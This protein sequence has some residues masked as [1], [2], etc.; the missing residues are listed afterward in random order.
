MRLAQPYQRKTH[1]TT[2]V[3]GLTR[4]LPLR[5]VDEDTWIASN[6]PVIFGDV[7][8]IRK[9]GKELASRLS[10]YDI[11]VPVTAEAKAEALA[12]EVTRALQLPHFIV[13]RK[14]VKSYMKDPL[15]T[16]LKSIT[17][18]K[19]QKLV[20]DETDAKKVRGKNVA[21]V[22]DVVTTGGNMNAMER[23]ILEA[24]GKVKAKACIWIEGEP[25][26]EQAHHARE[27]LIH[28]GYLPIFYTKDKYE[29]IVSLEG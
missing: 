4:K 18:E 21:L 9:T 8:L 10:K 22:D 24:G 27:D 6:H 5:K 19:P 20:L 25:L 17:T 28:L 2:E 14:E 29:E 3:C 23:L 1:Y 12:Y 26:T 11:D 13:C 16:E 7:E 15:I